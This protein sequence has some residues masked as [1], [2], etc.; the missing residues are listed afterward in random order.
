MVNSDSRYMITLTII[1]ALKSAGLSASMT[2][3]TVSSLCGQAE[4]IQE[5]W[6]KGKSSGQERPV[7]VLI[8][9]HY[10]CSRGESNEF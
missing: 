2:G 7:L 3:N 9:S 4:K 6:Y 8:E 10:Y 5:A 1:T